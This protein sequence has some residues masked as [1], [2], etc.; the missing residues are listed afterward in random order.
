MP[1]TPAPPVPI[2]EQ[3][4]ISR[5]AALL[6]APVRDETVMMDLESDCYYG[7]DD[8]G[9]DIWRRLESPRKF[10]ELVDVLTADYD[11]D[12]VAIAEDVRKLLLIMAAHN[13]VTLG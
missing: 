1:E 9:S 10:S 5:C 8:I 6:V 12:R 3:T 2:D 4:L 7:L 11:A 13:V